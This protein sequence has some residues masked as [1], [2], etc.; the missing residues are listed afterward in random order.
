MLVVGYNISMV[1]YRGIWL[2]QR[3]RLPYFHTFYHQQVSASAE[4]IRERTHFNRE[5]MPAMI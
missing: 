3:D 1:V 4:I 2:H 5:S